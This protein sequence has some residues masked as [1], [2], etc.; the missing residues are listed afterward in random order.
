MGDP[1]L[2]RRAVALAADLARRP[3]RTVLGASRSWAGAKGAYRLLANPKA[4][5]GALLAPHVADVRAGCAG[6]GDFPP[7]EDTTILDFSG[8]AGA[9]APPPSRAEVHPRARP[10]RAARTATLEIRALRVQP[11]AP[12]RPGKGA[13]NDPCGAWAVEVREDAPAAGATPLRRLLLTSWDCSDGGGAAKVA[14]AYAARW[15]VEEYHKALKTGAGIERAQLADAA[16][17]TRLLGI[18]AVVAARLLAAKFSGDVPAG[19][20]PFEPGFVEL[21]KAV[22]KGPPGAWTCRDVLRAVAMHGGFPGR[23]GDGEPGWQ[24]IWQGYLHLSAMLDG[25]RLARK[26]CG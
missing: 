20:G 10:G 6:Q 3:G 25:Y 1:R 22:G 14:G 12:W 9:A 16:A 24:T 4:S 13:G 8:R 5:H 23:K 15:L 17:V 2:A 11:R 21:V 7:V 19:Q 26:G 18:L